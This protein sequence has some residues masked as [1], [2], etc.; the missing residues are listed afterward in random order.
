MFFLVNSSKN[1][2]SSSS[3]HL[4]SVN[5]SSFFS[6]DDDD[7]RERKGEKSRELQVFFAP[8]SDELSG[9]NE[10]RRR[11]R[12][13]DQP[14]EQRRVGNVP[15]FIA[16]MQRETNEQFTQLQLKFK[17]EHE[18]KMRENEKM[19]DAIERLTRVKDDLLKSLTLM[20]KERECLRE[21]AM[22]KK[23][24]LFLRR[25]RRRRRRR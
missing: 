15:F 9:Q 12:R 19:R 1:S 24:K 10:R 5:S 11:R 3:S 23:L 16:R 2:F 14:G 17:R 22:G 18:E 4:R 25:R 6:F 21:K 7:E 20:T 13:E 8:S